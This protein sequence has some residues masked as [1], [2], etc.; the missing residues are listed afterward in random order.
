MS[1]FSDSTIKECPFCGHQP[2]I[3]DLNF[4]YPLS[5]LQAVWR[6]GCDETLGG[7][8]AEVIGNSKEDVIAKWN[9]RKGKL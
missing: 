2:K 5:K 8:T 4:A 6:A 3:D 7:C 1:L 9:Y